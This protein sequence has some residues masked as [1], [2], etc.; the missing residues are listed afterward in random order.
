MLRR[1]WQAFYVVGDDNTFPLWTAAPRYAGGLDFSTS[2]T[3]AALA[4]MG[5]T[6]VFSQLAV[7]PAVSTR[8]GVRRAYVLLTLTQV[9]F[10]LVQPFA[11][12]FESETKIV[13]PL[14]LSRSAGFGKR[15]V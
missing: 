7:Y 5:A 12:Q 3:G 9:P 4:M 11:S 1:A 13:R 14:P 10:F 8:L 2:A 15:M 6:V